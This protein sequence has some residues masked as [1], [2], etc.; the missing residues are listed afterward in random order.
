MWR[1][2]VA[3]LA[4]GI[5]EGSRRGRKLTVENYENDG[6]V[7]QASLDA[8]EY[9]NKAKAGKESLEQYCLNKFTPQIS[10]IPELNLSNLE[11]EYTR[12][13]EG[14]GDVRMRGIEL[15]IILNTVQSNKRAI[16]LAHK[17]WKKV[18][19]YNNAQQKKLLNDRTVQNAYSLY[20][21][22][23]SRKT[24]PV[25]YMRI[26][27]FDCRL[28][29]F[30]GQ[31]P[32][33]VWKEPTEVPGEEEVKNFQEIFK[34]IKEKCNEVFAPSA[35]DSAF[36]QANTARPLY[37]IRG[38]GIERELHVKDSEDALDQLTA[39]M[40]ENCD[41]DLNDIVDALAGLPW[42]A[43][44]LIIISV[45]LLLLLIAFLIYWCCCRV[46]SAGAGKVQKGG[47][48]YASYYEDEPTAVKTQE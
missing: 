44:L 31:E 47:D 9:S 48:E 3:L 2:V 45:I 18:S 19:V 20:D 39:F 22:T 7:C 37:R 21:K 11:L 12:N 23:G 43:I 5:A 26:S 14:Y 25:N 38:C 15:V 13:V 35:E 1:S 8:G 33:E 32:S 29:D 10:I 41:S 40:E 42:W 30:V 6:G 27:G 28:G 4:F 24:S 46:K 16:D 34:Q 36:T 17:A